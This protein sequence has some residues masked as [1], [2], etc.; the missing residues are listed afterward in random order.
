M[1]VSPRRGVHF[2][3]FWCSRLGKVM[4]PQSQTLPTTNRAARSIRKNRISHNNDGHPKS[5][6]T[7]GGSF[8]RSNNNATTKTTT[9]HI[10][11]LGERCVRIVF[12]FQFVHQNTTKS[13]H[14]VG[15]APT[16]TQQQIN[17]KSTTNATTN[18]TTK[19]LTPLGERRG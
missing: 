13:S 7:V 9:K 1:R 3:S 14:T 11:T 5:F 12:L 19:H 2:C 8:K 16:T 18:A 6:H 4:K 15:G 10:N 17:N